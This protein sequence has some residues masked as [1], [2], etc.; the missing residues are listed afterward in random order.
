MGFLDDMK[1][2]AQDV[3]ND[4]AARAKIEQIAKD[5]GISMEAAREHFL[6]HNDK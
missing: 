3:M 5:K 2:K 1:D 6:K 4:P